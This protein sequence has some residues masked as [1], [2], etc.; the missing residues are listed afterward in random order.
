LFNVISAKRIGVSRTIP[1]TG[2]AP[3]FATIIA[4]VFL[5]EEYSVYIFLGM[6]L[7]IFGIFTLTRRKE[8][9]IRVFDKKDLL[10]PLASAVGGGL[11]IVIAKVAIDKVGDPMI[12]VALTLGAALFVALGYVIST[13]KFY[14]FSIIHKGSI[15]PVLGGFSMAIAFF[16]NF[17]ALQMGSVSVVAPIFSTFPLFGVF[18]SHFI[19]REDITGRTWLGAFIIVVGIAVIQAF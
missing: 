11:S 17:S 3:F 13:R 10:F 15:F 6:A 2:T 4:I 5:Q 1:I 18:L 14:H 7:I 12:G 19:L 9:G 16:L 8:N